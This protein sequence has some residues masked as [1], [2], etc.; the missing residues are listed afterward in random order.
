MAEVLHAKW[1]IKAV[2]SSKV[3]TTS[4]KLKLIKAEHHI[5]NFI[6]VISDNTA[7]AR[8]TGG[9]SALPRKKWLDL[10]NYWC[11]NVWLHGANN[12]PPPFNTQH[13]IWGLLYA[14]KDK[15]NFVVNNQACGF[16]FICLQRIWLCAADFRKQLRGLEKN[17]AMSCWLAGWREKTDQISVCGVEKV[18]ESYAMLLG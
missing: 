9:P 11:F 12:Q 1:K 16:I 2:S 5:F 4:S 15:P 10:D 3:H 17:G 14:F 6:F 13:K 18:W 8:H 7:H